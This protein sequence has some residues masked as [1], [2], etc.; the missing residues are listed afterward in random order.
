M[1][2]KAVLVV[3]HDRR[4]RERFTSWLEAAGFETM[5]CPGPCAP[6]YSCVGARADVCPL[7]RA[8]DV[9]VL[10]LRL[11]S[12]D[13][14]LGTPAWQLLLYYYAHGHKIVAITGPTDA[15][16][17]LPDASVSVVLRPARRDALVGAV[18]HLAAA[19]VP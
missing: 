12:D 6:E 11:A 3:E 16:S 10:D 7:E 9:V 1:D 4:E 17:P 2:R 14:M 5:A 8:A 19:A 13:M 15:V 18:R